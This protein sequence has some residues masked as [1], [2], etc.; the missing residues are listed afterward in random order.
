[1]ILLSTFEKYLLYSNSYWKTLPKPIKAILFIYII[2]FFGGSL[3]HLADILH[4]GIFPYKNVPFIF[5]FYLTSLTILDLLTILLIFISPLYGVLFADFIMV[6]DL[7]IDFYLSYIYWN[8][9]ILTN[10]TLQLL[11]AFGFFVFI[12]S[13]FLI[14]QLRK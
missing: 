5:N 4:G 3:S 1:M 9:S 8:T 14:T 6:S 7:S 2:C 12:S 11:V 13:P 10:H